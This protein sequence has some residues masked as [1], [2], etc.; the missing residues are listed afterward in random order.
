MTI[1]ANNDKF[2]SSEITTT[3]SRVLRTYKN[4]FFTNINSSI[5]QLNPFSN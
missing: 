3:E 4:I 1:E 5:S 2:T